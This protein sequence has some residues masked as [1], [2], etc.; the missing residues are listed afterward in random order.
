VFL[1]LLLGFPLQSIQ[2]VIIDLVGKQ[3]FFHARHLSS[4]FNDL[5]AGWTEKLNNFMS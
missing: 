2:E 4:G 5:V 3:A 1:E